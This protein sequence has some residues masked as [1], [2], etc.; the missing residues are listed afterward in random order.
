MVSGIHRRLVLVPTDQ[1][2]KR[3]EL[4]LSEHDAN[5]CRLWMNCERNGYGAIKHQGKVYSTH[6]V[7][8]VLAGNDIAESSVVAHKCDVRLCCNPEHLENI[9]IADNNRDAFR[10]CKRAHLTGELVHN[11]VLNDDLVRK[12]I[13]LYVPNKYSYRRIAK[14]LGVSEL[15]VSAVIDG[16]TWT[17][18]PRKPGMKVRE[19]AQ[20]MFKGPAPV[21]QSIGD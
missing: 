14:D 19:N 5:G 3:F 8:W 20:Y 15:A 11:A 2:R 21:L 17:H 4:G 10:R 9:S 7:A 6:V 12:I 1:L 18:I 13:E 16:E